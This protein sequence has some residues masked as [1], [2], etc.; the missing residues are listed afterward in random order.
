[1]N[2]E[3]DFFD[4][5]LLLGST[6][7]YGEFKAET[8]SERLTQAMLEKYGF[9]FKTEQELLDKHKELETLRK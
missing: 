1:M 8:E 9:Y 3:K 5:M 6:Y 7:Y 4:L 2:I